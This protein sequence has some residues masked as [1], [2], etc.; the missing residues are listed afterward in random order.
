MFCEAVVT[1]EKRGLETLP[2]FMLNIFVE[3]TVYI[4]FVLIDQTRP[5]LQSGLVKKFHKLVTIRESL[6]QQ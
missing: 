6:D 4:F 2:L 1:P 5:S 3:L